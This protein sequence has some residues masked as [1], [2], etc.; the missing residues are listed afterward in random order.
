VA[1]IS[2]L[3]IDGIQI[4]QQMLDSRQLDKII[5]NLNSELNLALKHFST[6]HLYKINKLSLLDKIYRESTELQNWE[7]NQRYYQNL[8]N[9]LLSFGLLGTFVGITINLFLLSRNTGGEIPLDKTLEDIIGSMAI[10]FISSL[11]ALI[12]SVIITKFHPAYDLEI[13]RNDIFNQLE[14]YLDNECQILLDLP[15]VQEKINDLIQTLLNLPQSIQEL[16][17]SVSISSQNL[18]TSG[19]TFHS[20]IQ[21]AS[22]EITNTTNILNNTTSNLANIT[23]NFANFTSTLKTSATSLDQTTIALE[24]YNQQLQTAINNLTNHSSRIQ[25]LVQS[26]HNELSQV[27]LRLEENGNSLLSST[28]TFNINASQ[29]KE[30]LNNHTGQVNI[31]NSSLQQLS[32]QIDSYNHILQRIQQELQNICHAL[33]TNN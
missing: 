31:H 17:K 3:C 11:G 25:N 1:L 5:N 18:V 33:N 28:Q 21:D 27:S 30:A 10:A 8:P 29:V 2:K 15:T 22:S 20:Q 19:N 9:L 14:Y 4:K 6:N 7:K 12:S 13:A 23:Q 16:E 26:N 32:N 24:N